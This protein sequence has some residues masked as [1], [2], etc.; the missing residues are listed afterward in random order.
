L[1]TYVKKGNNLDYVGAFYPTTQTDG[2]VNDWEDCGQYLNLLL[3]SHLNMANFASQAVAFE[4]EYDSRIALMWDVRY[5]Y[6]VADGSGETKRNNARNLLI[7]G[8][9]C[10]KAA[11]TNLLQDDA[12]R[13]DLWS[14]MMWGGWIVD[15]P[16][17]TRY[18]SGGSDHWGSERDPDSIAAKCTA[19][20]QA[21][22]HYNDV[23]DYPWNLGSP[24]RL[25]VFH[26]QGN[27]SEAAWNYDQEACQ[28]FSTSGDNC[29]KQNASTWYNSGYGINQWG[30]DSYIQTDDDDQ[31]IKD[32]RNFFYDEL[33][34]D[35]GLA[36][37]DTKFMVM[38]GRAFSQ[39][40]SY[41]NWLDYTRMRYYYDCAVNYDS[42]RSLYWKNQFSALLWYAY[43]VADGITGYKA[44]SDVRE[45]VQCISEDNW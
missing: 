15:E 36:D 3:V 30:M 23:Y 39:P 18:R 40:N 38:V 25:A 42:S 9:D 41:P 14:Q 45:D 1:T 22:Y 43:V 7:G 35:L 27:D 8:M 16:I 28:Y 2:S 24:K 10:V 34:D 11:I 32:D 37:K 26:R 31:M 20:S 19:L 21:F 13:H 4:N 44:E 6:H 5:A 33:V 17:S 29:F 12:Q